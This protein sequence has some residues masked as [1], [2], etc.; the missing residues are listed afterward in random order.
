MGTTLKQIA[1][2]KFEKGSSVSEVSREM[3]VSPETA[4]KWFEARDMRCSQGCDEPASSYY[5][6]YGGVCN[7]CDLELGRYGKSMSR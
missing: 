6:T 1:W 2:R 4:L 5:P 3:G 7:E